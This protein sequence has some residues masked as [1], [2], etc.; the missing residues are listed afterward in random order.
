MAQVGD[1]ISP[2]D[3]EPRQNPPEAAV[4]RPP[5]APTATPLERRSSNTANSLRSAE[6]GVSVKSKLLDVYNYSTSEAHV[7][8]PRSGKEDMCQSSQSRT[9]A[10]RVHFLFDELHIGIPSA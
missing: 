8:L 7:V 4:Q 3:S 1:E 9:R 10:L 6:E 2:A 5:S